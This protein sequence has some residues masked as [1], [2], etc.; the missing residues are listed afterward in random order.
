MTQE[1]FDRTRDLFSERNRMAH[2]LEN[3]E[4]RGCA[5]VTPGKA[6]VEDASEEVDESIYIAIKNA[7]KVR[8]E[9]LNKTIERL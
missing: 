9:E 7:V 8:F 1:E 3:L 6:G 5:I 4:K 2:L